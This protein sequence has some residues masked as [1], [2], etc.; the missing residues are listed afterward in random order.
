MGLGTFVDPRNG[1]G[2]LNAR[3]TEDLV[4]L[5]TIHGEECLFYPARPVDVAL[6][7]GTTADADGNITMEKEALFLE[8]LA[9][10]GAVHNSGG[11]VIVQVERLAQRGTLPAKAVKIP[12]VLVNCVVVAEDPEHNWQTLSTPYDAA[13]A[14]EVRVPMQSIAP[15]PLGVRKVIARRAAF[16]LRPN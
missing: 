3:T 1:G 11:L 2:K 14:G 12:G 13:F 8:S 4:E 10:A 9:I 7:R 5:M 6:L 16:E 15:M